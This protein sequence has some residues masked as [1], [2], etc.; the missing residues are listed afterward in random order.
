MQMFESRQIYTVS[1]PITGTNKKRR[2]LTINLK[3]EHVLIRRLIFM[4]TISRIANH[5]SCFSL[6]SINSS[7]NK[8]DS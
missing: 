8:T 4:D 2:E 5:V 3:I 7:N 6:N 1:I